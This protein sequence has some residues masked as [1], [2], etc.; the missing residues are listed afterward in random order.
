MHYTISY[1]KA[2]RHFFRVELKF[3]LNKEENIKFQLPSWRPGRYELGNFAKNIR[4]FEVIRE[5][6]QRL[7]Y[8]KVTK[9]CWKIEC[10]GAKSVRVSYSFYANELNAGSSYLDE[11]QL[12][13][14]PINCCGYI[15][16]R[17]LESGLLELH[18]PEDYQ[19][20]IALK[21]RSRALFEFGNFDQLVESPFIASASLKKLEYRVGNCNFYLWFQGEANYDES[22]LIKDFT[23]FT[24]YQ[25]ERFG[26]I[27][28]DEYHYLYQITP[29]KSYHGVEHTACTV[30]SLGPDK[31][32]FEE[33]LYEEFLGVSSHELYHTWN[34]KDLRPK[35]MS[36]YDYTGE[37]Y[38][39]L[40]YIYEGLT[41]YMGD[42]CLWESGVYSDEQFERALQQWLEKHFYNE[43]RKNLSVADSSFDTWLDGYTLGIPGRKVSIYQD[44]ALC[45]LMIDSI[46]R[47]G[48]E[49][50]SSL[51]D[52]AR[53]MFESEEIRKNGYTEASIR[54]LMVEY[55]G[56]DVQEI[57]DRHIY[58]TDDYFDNLKIAFD[59]FG[60]S[61]QLEKNPNPLESRLGIQMMNKDGKGY[62]Y[63]VE[64]DSLAD[65]NGIAVGDSIELLNGDNLKFE[66]G[67]YSSDLDYFE[68]VLQKK[69]ETKKLKIKGAEQK[70]YPKYTVKVN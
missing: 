61:L 8:Q 65:I 17:E 21:R 28:V 32:V 67:A 58:G 23:D 66:S 63:R 4:D 64:E 19:V 3:D 10:R 46:I 41:T 29:F 48:S 31:E 54:Q 42:L 34:I 16:G 39:R 2:H 37:N 13:V 25:M 11:H 68:L 26:D 27:P 22:R 59:Y 1:Q 15:Q 52:V 35:E 18:I 20:A 14:N 9:D 70:Y 5:D 33:E 44:G 51:H 69:F 12:Y 55:G 57:F 50:K 56:E 49:G 45:M 53:A 6:G 40:G 30:I 62:I 43:G 38:S 60:W 7:D 36:P 24:A 47:K